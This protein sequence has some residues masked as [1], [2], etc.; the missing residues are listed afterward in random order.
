MGPRC[1]CVSVCVDDTGQLFV[2]LFPPSKHGRRR[3]HE[4]AALWLFVGNKGARHSMHRCGSTICSQPNQLCCYLHSTWKFSPVHTQTR[5]CTHSNALTRELGEDPAE[6]SKAAPQTKEFFDFTIVCVCLCVMADKAS[7]LPNISSEQ[8]HRR[9]TRR[10]K[11]PDW[12]FLQLVQQT[13]FF[14]LYL[15]YYH[16]HHIRLQLLL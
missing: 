15:C 3:L 12:W 2:D 5:T 14:P 13:P 7:V 1:I 6:V 4:H 10:Q 16:V 8:T 11:D 9:P